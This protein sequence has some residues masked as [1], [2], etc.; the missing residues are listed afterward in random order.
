MNLA[1]G[2]IAAGLGHVVGETG[3]CDGAVREDPSAG[4][5][6]PVHGGRRQQTV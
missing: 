1:L 3:V 2:P 5:Y 6:F 4:V